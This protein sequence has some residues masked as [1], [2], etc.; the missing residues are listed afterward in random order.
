MSR[1]LVTTLEYFIQLLIFYSIVMYFAE[2]EFTKTEHSLAAPKFFLWSERIVAVLFTVEL[3]VRTWYNKRHPITPMGIIDVLAVLPFYIGFF[4]DLR[5]LRLVRTLR[6]LRTLK[7]YRYNKALRSFTTTFKRIGDELWIIGTVVA[8]LVLISGTMIYECE[9]QV[10]PDVFGN[11]SDGLWWS[12][13]TLTTVGYGDTFPVT[14]AGRVVAVLTTLIGLGIF[15]VL[16]SLFGASFTAT[17]KE[18]GHED[19]PD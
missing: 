17:L 19:I 14:P 18:E 4:V 7:F 15:G 13:I 12:W 6:I 3:A 1:K 11:L 9:R 5:M 8:F 10:Q 16:I 2:M